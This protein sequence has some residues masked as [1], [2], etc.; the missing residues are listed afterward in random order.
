MCVFSVELRNCGNREYIPQVT[1]TVGFAM[2]FTLGIYVERSAR[3]Q[4]RGCTSGRSGVSS[5]HWL[6]VPF[7]QKVWREVVCKKK[8]AGFCAF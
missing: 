1:T 5:R 3:D 2:G 7:L 8:A 4:P 6:C